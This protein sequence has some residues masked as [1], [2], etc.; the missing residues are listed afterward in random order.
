MGCG[1][2]MTIS[3]KESYHKNHQL[4]QLK[5]SV[6]LIL[7]SLDKFRGSIVTIRSL[8]FRDN[9]RTLRLTFSVL[10]GCGLRAETELNRMGSLILKKLLLTTKPK[11]AFRLSFRFQRF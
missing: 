7:T 5:L 9:Y 4:S 6:S 10:F 1:A 2:R 3:E 8:R 11:R